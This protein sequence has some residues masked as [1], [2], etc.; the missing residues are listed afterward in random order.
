MFPGGDDEK[1]TLDGIDLTWFDKTSQ[2]LKAGT[3]AFKASRRILIDKTSGKSKRPLT[4][5]S[6]RDKI[7]QEGMRAIL[8]SIYEPQFSNSSYGFRPGRS[9]HMAL[10]EVKGWKDCNWFIEIDY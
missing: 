4:V 1:E 9:C 2:R 6:P 3:H 5:G 7:I 10:K 8:S